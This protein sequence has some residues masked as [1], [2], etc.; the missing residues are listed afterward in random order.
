MTVNY[1]IGTK[2]KDTKDYKLNDSYIEHII[3]KEFTR[4][5]PLG[6]TITKTTGYYTHDDG[7][8]IEEKGYIVTVLDTNE[9]SHMFACRLKG[10]LNQESIGVQ[11]INDSI[12]FE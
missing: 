1:Y 6:F 9:V 4:R 8:V 3:K 12:T 7:Q 5:Y 10:L 11:V 2:D